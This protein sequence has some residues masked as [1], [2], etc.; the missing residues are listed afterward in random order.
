[1]VQRRAV[2]SDSRGSREM[3]P[4]TD[5]RDRSGTVGVDRVLKG[6][7]SDL[8]L[9]ERTVAEVVPLDRELKD[10]HVVGRRT[11]IDVEEIHPLD[12][13]LKIEQLLRKRGNHSAA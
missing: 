13:E 3:I 11:L 6:L 9:S 4:F 10:V 7:I 1:M 2:V 5:K 8:D 12:R